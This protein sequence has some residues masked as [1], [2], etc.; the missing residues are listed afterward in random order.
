MSDL[1]R[2]DRLDAT[3]RALVTSSL[4]LDHELLSKEDAD[5][6]GRL[7]DE[8][9]EELVDADADGVHAVAT[10]LVRFIVRQELES[11]WQ[12][13]CTEEAVCAGWSGGDDF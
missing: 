13:Y 9:V 3:A 2:Y 8:L 4:F 11:E 6:D 7:A 5:I 12:A 10:Q 1:D